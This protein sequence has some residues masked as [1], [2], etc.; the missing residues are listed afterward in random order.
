MVVDQRITW[1]SLLVLLLFVGLFRRC[2]R[3][4]SLLEVVLPYHVCLLLYFGCVFHRR[5]LGAGQR[6]LLRVHEFPRK[7]RDPIRRAA[8]NIVTL[9]VK[10]ADSLGESDTCVKHVLG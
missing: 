10:S 9:G 6:G 3:S 8:T 2:P 5:F 4:I 7:S 1:K